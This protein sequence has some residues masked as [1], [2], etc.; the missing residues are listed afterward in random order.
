MTLKVLSADLTCCGLLANL[1][2][3]CFSP[4]WD[5]AAFARLITMPGAFA[6]LLGREELEEAVP[7]AFAL[8]RLAGGEC[9]IITLGV[10][11]DHRKMGAGHRL[12]RAIVARAGELGADELLLEVAADNPAAIALYQSNAFAPVGRRK[13]YYRHGNDSPVDAVVMRRSLRS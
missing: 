1:H 10:L 9:E 4:A 5:E 7:I 13:D 11:P 2:A 12:I 8:A 6:L 3:L